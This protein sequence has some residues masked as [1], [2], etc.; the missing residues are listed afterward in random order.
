MWKDSPMG[1]WTPRVVSVKT[2]QR[3]IDSVLYPPMEPSSP[4]SAVVVLE[5]AR[6]FRRPQSALARVHECTESRGSQGGNKERARELLAEDAAACVEYL[7]K[8]EKIQRAA[9]VGFGIGGEA[10]LCIAAKSAVQPLSAIV[11]YYALPP[12]DCKFEALACPTL[13]HISRADKESG[14]VFPSQ[15]LAQLSERVVTTPASK[16]QMQL[17]AS[18]NGFADESSSAYNP[19]DALLAWDWTLQFLRTHLG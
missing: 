1:D 7:V 16:C 15:E 17:Y 8:A 13:V 19:N 5:G 6:P 4:L 11:S 10:A 9:I 12:A 18:Q 2:G 14:S 3:T